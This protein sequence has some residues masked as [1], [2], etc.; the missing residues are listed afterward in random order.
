[1]QTCLCLGTR[2]MTLE[3]PGGNLMMASP[4][5][6]VGEEMTHY[7]YDTSRVL[8]GAART[9]S[10]SSGC[11]PERGGDRAPLWPQPAL[12]DPLAAVATQ[13]RHGGD[14]AALRTAP[15]DYPRAVRRR[16]GAD[17]GPS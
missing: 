17:R 3:E 9:G 8:G 2:P 7:R 11:R 6:P 13:T 10:P 15:Q 14:Q 4:V 5:A 16:A 12:A 1:M